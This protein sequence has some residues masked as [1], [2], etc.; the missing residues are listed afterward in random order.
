M[1][2]ILIDGDGGRISIVVERYER[3]FAEN[4][5]DANWLSCNARATI[6]SFFG[7]SQ[8]AMT[9]S[10]LRRF[11]D[12]LAALVLN[13]SE[14]AQLDTMEENIRLRF[15]SHA[16]GKVDIDGAISEAGQRAVLNFRFLSD[17]PSLGQ[18]V[19]ALDFATSQFPEITTLS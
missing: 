16:S 19:A 9:A 18:A 4:L 5:D 2:E 14:M 11:R 10:E 12:S 7:A 3:E 17:L 8:L 6:R 13:Q 1:S 15:R